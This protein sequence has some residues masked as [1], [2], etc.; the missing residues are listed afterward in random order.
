MLL[1]FSLTGQD[2]TLLSCRVKD[3]YISF[4]QKDK[5]PNNI[6]ILVE[7]LNH[8]VVDTVSQRGFPPT[9]CKCNDSIATF[10]FNNSVSPVLYFI[11]FDDNEWKYHDFYGPPRFPLVG[12][13][14]EGERYE[15]FTSELISP[16][17]L[18][19]VLKVY[20]GKRDGGK[21]LEEQY[22]IVSK[23]LPNPDWKPDPTEPPSRRNHDR[24]KMKMVEKVAVPI[25][26]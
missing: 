8:I 24:Y 21:V 6:F 19:A 16:T 2:S 22:E 5:D 20:R 23:V 17:E 26:E 13:L 4:V 18:H 12:I 7:D 10:Y 25:Q 11:K 1:A 15:K 3:Q 9:D 14:V